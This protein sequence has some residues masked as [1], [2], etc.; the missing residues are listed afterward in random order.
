VPTPTPAIITHPYLILQFYEIN[1]NTGLFPRECIKSEIGHSF[2]RFPSSEVVFM[3]K[4]LFSILGTAFFFP[5]PAVPIKRAIKSRSIP[6][7]RFQTPFLLATNETTSPVLPSITLAKRCK[8]R[9]MVVL[10]RPVSLDKLRVSHWCLR[11]PPID[12][13]SGFIHPPP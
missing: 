2:T 8:Q 9:K 7:T 1:E 5:I 4:L 3:L 13:A 12:F 11:Q 10:L 6:V